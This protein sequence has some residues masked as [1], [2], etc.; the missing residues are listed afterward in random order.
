ML[1]LH[2]LPACI[3]GS[4]ER[5]QPQTSARNSS[6]AAGAAVGWL[7]FIYSI[8]PL[9]DWMTIALHPTSSCCPLTDVEA[10]S[11]ASSRLYFWSCLSSSLRLTLLPIPTVKK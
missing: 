2:S 10:T 1:G 4:V 7:T 5:M 9:F 6:R 3:C 8:P 11:R